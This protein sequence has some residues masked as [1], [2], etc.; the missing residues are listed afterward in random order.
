MVGG[1]TRNSLLCQMAADATGL[2]VFAGPAEATIMGNLA[3]Q[4]IAIKQLKSAEQIRAVAR[5][6]GT[7]KRYNPRQQDLWNKNFAGYKQISA[8]HI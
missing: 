4:A 3:V 8:K 1:G 6:S 5:N 7:I 2:E